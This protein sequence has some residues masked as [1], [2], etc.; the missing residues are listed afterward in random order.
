[1]SILSSGIGLLPI[2]IW[3][4]EHGWAGANQLA[5]RVGLSSRATWVSIYPVLSFVCGEIIALGVIW[6]IVG[7]AA[8]GGILTR[9]LRPGSGSAGNA[10]LALGEGHSLN[11][12][13]LLYLLCLWGVLWC[14]CLAAAVLG[15][16]EANWMVPGYVAL[17]V[18]IAAR[19]DR[20]S[21]PAARKPAPTLRHGVSRSWRSLLS[22]IWSGSIP[23]LRTGYR[24]QQTA[25]RPRFGS[26]SRP[27]G[28]A[29]TKL[30]LE[31]SLKR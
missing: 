30:W 26:M 18:L 22:I 15:E 21:R 23:R 27:R 11:R 3:N 24:L 6:W 17:V 7:V 13:G 9:L 28:C 19:V 4:A 16:T 31:R 14:A 20:D 25:G 5:D 12:T 8:L 2:F 1:M 29:D 10:E